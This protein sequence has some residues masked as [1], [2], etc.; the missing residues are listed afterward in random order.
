VLILLLNGFSLRGLWLRAP[1]TPD[2]RRGSRLWLW[3]V[4]FVL[5]FGALQFVPW[6]LPVLASLRDPYRQLSRVFHLVGRAA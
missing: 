6:H 1:S 5:G 4:P 2:G 3:S